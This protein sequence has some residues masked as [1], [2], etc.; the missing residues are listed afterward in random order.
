MIYPEVQKKIQEEIDRVIGRENDIKMID[1]TRLPYLQACIQELQ[2]IVV[3]TNL[4]LPRTTLEDV[5]IGGY[6]VSKGTTIIAQIA[7]VHMDDYYFKDPKVFD[8]TRHLDESGHFVKDDKIT[9]FSV[10]KR[11]CL[12]ESLARMELFLFVANLFQKFEFK[13]EKEGK[14]PALEFHAGFFKAPVPFV[15][16]PVYRE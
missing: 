15:T 6:K 5:S 2:R 11:A 7:A 3:L 4:N 16:R 12:G 10:G 14:P 13:P 1:Q 8:P 9:P